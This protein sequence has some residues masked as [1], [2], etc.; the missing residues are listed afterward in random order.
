[1]SATITVT[2][3]Y[4]NLPVCHDAGVVRVRLRSPQTDAILRYFDIALA[5]AETDAD[6]W[7]FHDVSEFAGRELVVSPAD[8]DAAVTAAIA[9]AARF[10]DEPLAL[11]G[12]YDEALRPQYHFSSRRG[13]LNDPNGLVCVDGTWHLFYQHN[14]FGA[15]W[16]NMHW[17]HAT[18]PDL[19]HWTEH[20]DALL[21][22][23]SGTMYSG[24]AVVDHTNASGLQTG[25]QPP[26]L[27]FYTS[28]GAQAPEPVDYTQG[29]AVSNDGGRT[30][31]KYHDNPIIDFIVHHN[32]DPKVL[33]HAPSGNWVMVLFLDREQEDCNAFAIFTSSNLI[34][35]AR[36]DTVMLP[37]RG[38]CPD[39][40]PLRTAGE[41]ADEHWV[42]IGADG[43]YKLGTFDGAQF[44]E[45]QAPAQLF[46]RV[47][48][49]NLYAGQTFSN[50]PD[51]RRIMVAWHQARFPQMPFNCCMSVPAELT[52]RR[53]A[54]GLRLCAQPVTEL[55]ALSC[56]Q[57]TVAPGNPA[58]AFAAEECLD[59][60]LTLPVTSGVGGLTVH[61]AELVLDGDARQV[62]LADAV[63]N[64]A[65]DSDSFEI[66]MLVDRSTVELFVDGGRTW[67]ATPLP[68]GSARG[69]TR[70]G[71]AE[72]AIVCIRRLARVW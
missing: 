22:D 33:Y 37:G 35:W 3:R 19:M 41:P 24:S 47:G 61:G 50:T 30:F 26:V 55:D 8:D 72:S 62:R 25:T 38:E 9:A 46:C 21:P 16:G 45:T 29:L 14:P 70:S 4:L 57:Q 59:I 10:S 54:D 1:M 43:C 2:G 20:D 12:C 28:A 13:W 18:S 6:F 53:F 69:M 34:D 31:E 40:F 52:L 11:D 49:D 7:V 58:P 36:T 63:I 56:D 48:A 39:L 64:L 51:D 44:S 27:L 17:G 71:I 32:R 60:A 66:R 5:G 67:F 68:A 65:P 42:F 23:A 15:N